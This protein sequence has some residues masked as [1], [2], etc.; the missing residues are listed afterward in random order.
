MHRIVSDRELQQAKED[1]PAASRVAPVEAEDELVQVRL[2]V[3]PIQVV[4]TIGVRAE[5]CPK[6]ALR[7]RV[8]DAGK[9][10]HI[11]SLVRLSGY[12]FDAIW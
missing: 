7:P 12:P 8:V 11:R 10:S 5:P 1:Q 3:S 4:P 6:L 2:Q 9:W